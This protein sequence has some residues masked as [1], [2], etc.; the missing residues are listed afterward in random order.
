MSPRTK[1]YSAKDVIEDVRD[2]FIN[3]DHWAYQYGD[4]TPECNP[5]SPYHRKQ[6]EVIFEN[7]YDH[8]DVNNAVDSLVSQKFLRKKRSG[9]A[10]FVFRSNVRYYIREIKRRTKIIEAYSDPT[11]TRALGNWAEKI[12]EYMCGLNGFE[13]LGRNTNE[14][15]GKRWAGTN[16]NLDFIIGKDYIAYGI[17]VKNTLPYMETDEFLRKIAMCGFLGL[18]PL[19]IVR[20][21]PEVQFNTMKAS[22]GL[23]LA[24]KV[25]MYPYGQE[26]L[27]KRIWN[28]MRLPVGVRAEMPQKVVNSLISFHKSLISS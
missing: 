20:N 2:F 23:I 3:R 4:P 1:V 24:S 27:T 21:A 15:Q 18:T 26:P 17:E 19:W 9:N 11:I 13:I 22:R 16:E 14:F 7:R 25:Q 12:V 10:H 6:I 28:K 8:W 5:N